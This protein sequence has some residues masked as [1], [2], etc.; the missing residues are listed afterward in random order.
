M[1]IGVLKD[2]LY[3]HNASSNFVDQ[4]FREDPMVFSKILFKSLLDTSTFPLVWAW[5]GVP[6]LWVTPYLDNKL[7]NCLFTKWVPWSLMITRGVLDLENIFFKENHK[8]HDY[9]FFLV[10]TASTHLET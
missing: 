8:Q 5:Y 10:A 2:V 3:D 9:H 6:V 7:A 4:Y 1:P